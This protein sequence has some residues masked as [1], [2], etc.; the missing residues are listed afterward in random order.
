M[1]GAFSFNRS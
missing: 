1:L